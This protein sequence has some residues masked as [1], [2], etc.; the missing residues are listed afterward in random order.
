MNFFKKGII[1]TQILIAIV[2]LLTF[3]LGSPLVSQE[4]KDVIKNEV[5]TFL[6]AQQ[7]QS[8]PVVE[9]QEVIVETPGAET[10]TPTETVETVPV[11][12]ELVNPIYI[13][14]TIT[15]KSNGIE[16]DTID[17]S[18]GEDIKFVWSAVG[19]NVL[20]CEINQSLVDQQGVTT[21]KVTES[22][23]FKL[24][25]RDVVTGSRFS[26]LVQVNIK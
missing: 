21:V 1:T 10:V 15:I 26:K 17:V 16:R 13:D 20:R 24:D 19:Q 11:Q 12:T 25:C 14:P 18:S 4:Q 3:I 9:Q 7:S 5:S 23:T 8:N 6:V 22:F 2:T